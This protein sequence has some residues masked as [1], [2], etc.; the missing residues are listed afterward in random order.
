MRRLAPGLVAAALL[1]LAAAPADARLRVLTTGD[2]LVQ[3]LDDLMVKPVERAGGRALKDPRPATAITRPLILDWVKHARKQVRKYRPS[4]TVVFIGAGDT[5]PLPSAGGPLVACCRRAWIDAY[6]DRVERM[7]R[8]YMRRERH[9]VY[10]LT[11]P[12]PRQESRRPQFLAINYAIRQAARKAG[13]NAHVVDTVPVLSPRNR[14]RR[15]R[16]YHGRRVV[17]RDGDGVHLTTAGSRMVRDLVARTMRRDGVLARPS[18]SAAATATLAYERPLGELDIPAAYALTVQAGSSA[19]RISIAQSAT[20]YVITDRAAPLQAG[21][22]CIAVR[23]WAVRCPT[24]RT[25][26]DRSLF[27]DAARGNDL[28][29]LKSLGGDTM[30]EAR[31]GG[32]ADLIFGGAGNDRLLGGAGRDG[33]SGS[34]GLDTLDGGPGDDA[35]HGGTERDAVSYQ[36]RKRPVTVDLA[37]GTGGSR[38]ERDVLLDVEGVIG[39]SAADV[40]LGSGGA[41][42]LVGG[43]GSARDR[44]RGRG[45]DDGLIGYRAVGGRGADVLDAQRPSCGRGDDVIFRRTHT[46]PGPFPRACERII[47]IF[48][49]LRPQPV[50]SSRSAAV[51]GVR[52]ERTSR[53]RGALELRDRR[54]KIGKRSFA[55]RRRGDSVRLHRVRVPL[56]RRPDERVVTLRI[57]GVRAYQLST[58][59]VR[60]R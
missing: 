59:R 21:A 17:V 26:G 47:A 11:L 31:G 6:A 40:I 32:G 51:F 29:W 57:T 35:L 28:I 5:E 41:D 58:F 36:T 56:A 30:A 33:L 7:M 55:L 13:P 25:V 52:C 48:T 22:G 16:R 39:S 27:V 15:K 42:T 23:P 44:L 34:G 53:C 2:S 24:P 49:V 10:W 38:G 19:N 14:F 50:R 37:R 1:L 8:T 18:A 45:G 54:G 20:E 12:A 46:P 9:H 43:E 3:P 60:L 4:A